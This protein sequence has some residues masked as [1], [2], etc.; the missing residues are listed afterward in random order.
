[1]PSN[2]LKSNEE[3]TLL[4][5]LRPSKTEAGRKVAQAVIARLEITMA[6]E[7]ALKGA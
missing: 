4:L 5:T 2:I 1:M 7:S 6:I 3:I